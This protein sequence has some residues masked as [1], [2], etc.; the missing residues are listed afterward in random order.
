MQSN[1]FSIIDQFNNL[2][3]PSI[4]KPLKKSKSE[5]GEASNIADLFSKM[6]QVANSLASQEGLIWI[7]VKY[8]QDTLDSLHANSKDNQAEDKTLTP[9]IQTQLFDFITQKREEYLNK[10][11]QLMELYLKIQL[12]HENRKPTS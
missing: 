4:S 5:I 1:R 3:M 7:Q 10:M 8:T 12:E 11:M 6:Y 9:L 2:Y